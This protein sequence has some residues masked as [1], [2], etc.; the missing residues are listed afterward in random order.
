M[1]RWLDAYGR[2]WEVGDPEAVGS[3]FAE[4]ARYQETPF[5]APM[6][7]RSAI[8]EYWS[9]IR[10]TQ[11][12]IHFNAKVLANTG[13]LAIIHWQASFT[14]LPSRLQVKL[15]GIL[16]LSFDNAGLCKHLREWWV[17][18]EGREAVT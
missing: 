5:T 1:K 10:R 14:R 4:D 17:R 18:Q 6:R 2:A 9:H 13:N 3:L 15:D 8:M 16:Q 11:E 7:G 12:K